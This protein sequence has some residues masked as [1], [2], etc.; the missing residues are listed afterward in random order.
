MTLRLFPALNLLITVQISVVPYVNAVSCSYSTPTITT[1]KKC[2]MNEVEWE[3]EKERKQCHLIIQN[4]T[5]AKKFQYHCLPDKSIGTYLEVC[6]P[7]LQTVG[8][9][10]PYYDTELKEIQLNYEQP[11]NEHSNPCPNFY[12]SN[13]VHKYQDCYNQ[14]L[15]KRKEKQKKS[16]NVI[17]KDIEE[18]PCQ[19]KECDQK[20]KT[21]KKTK[22][23]D[24]S[25]LEFTETK[26]TSVRNGIFAIC[27]LNAILVVLAIIQIF[28]PQRC[29]RLPGRI[30]RHDNNRKKS[31]SNGGKLLMLKP[32]GKEILSKQ[33]K[34]PYEE[35][36]L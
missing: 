28:C 1:V 4:C 10:C 7:I 17:S 14:S 25:N 24:F 9:Y 5:H 12:L 18:P 34:E 31:E 3:R 20:S 22:E 21:K 35:H 13:L 29:K 19:D 33:P 32:K 27:I 2:P 6:A 11:C 23:N 15:N 30:R 8:H 36:A 26:D 16:N